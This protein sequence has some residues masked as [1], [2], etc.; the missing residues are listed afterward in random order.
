MKHSI[1]KTIAALRKEKMWTQVELAE[2]LNVSDKTVSKWE[3]EAGMPE[4]SQLPVMAE[5]FGVSIDYLMT[6][7]EQEKEIVTMSKAELCAKT[8]DVSLAE[9]V[10]DLTKDE[11]N[12]NVVDYILEYQSLNVFKKLCESDANF[13]KRFKIVDAI[14][15]ATLSNS[16][17]LL[18]GKTFSI[19]ESYRFT[20]ENEDEIKSLLPL[21]DKEYFRDYQAQS[22]CLLPR[23][24][25]TL[26]ATDK[27]IGENTLNKL[28]SNQN[29]RE[30]VWYHAFPYM[31]DEA[32]KHG[33]R[34]ILNRLLD[35]SKENNSI[36]YDKIKPTYDSYDRKYDYTLNYFFI[37]YG[38]G[39]SGYGLV[40]ILESTIKESLSRGDW[41]IV[42]ELNDINVN[43]D[44]FVRSNFGRVSESFTKSKCYVADDDEI[45]VAKLKFDKSIPENKIA[46][47]SA[48]H[49]G[50]ISIKELLSINDLETIKTALYE[51]PLHIFEMLYR[52][53]EKKQW[54]KIFEIAVDNEDNRLADAVWKLKTDEIESA[55]LRYW[56]ENRLTKTNTAWVNDIN[57][58]ELYSST[59]EPW[60]NGV[61]GNRNQQ[62]LT[63]VEN[64][65]SE[66]RTR[67]I[68]EISDLNNRNEIITDLTK[69]FFM[70][71]L[72]KGNADIVVIKL[73]VRL[74]AILKYDYH[75]E[76][77]FSEMLD[78]YCS[79][80]TA[81]DD[82]CSTDDLHTATILNN[83]RK[84]RNNLV[85]AMKK[86]NKFNVAELKECI[87]Y[88][89]SL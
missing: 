64:Y 60:V 11:N 44:N 37:A 10:K 40:R 62:T 81:Y 22:I 76:G 4:I 67:I 52:L 88:I 24:F 70:S 41:D 47:Q 80:F 75:Y 42:D 20:F 66:V 49:N 6:G 33:N 26:L 61:R 54:R 3:S 71:E 23:E 28:L 15:L 46:V 69:E 18:C 58:D 89:C 36:A 63:E 79:R 27:R 7:K 78:Q 13:I 82:E 31:I 5:L 21:E 73:C 87:E 43:V 84:Q 34:Q 72:E 51:Y 86:G 74:E 19:N 1:G 85:H 45:R 2:K 48:I 12:K 55:I 9:E 17:Y 53:Y 14:T 56:T 83:L 16:L 39:N 25:F 65:L 57:Q 35:I 59:K 50:I 32:Y 8:D 29:G 30:C 77:D 68:D 38:Y